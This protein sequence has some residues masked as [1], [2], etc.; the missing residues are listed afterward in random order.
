MRSAQV[1]LLW[2]SVDQLHRPGFDPPFFLVIAILS[3][4]CESMEKFWKSLPKKMSGE[5]FLFP[6][7]LMAFA[8]KQ[9]VCHI[10]WPKSCAIRKPGGSAG[11][12]VNFFTKIF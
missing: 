3:D 9:Q 7:Y 1:V 12:L 5:E 6:Y 8:L 2:R 11:F 4:G 10:L